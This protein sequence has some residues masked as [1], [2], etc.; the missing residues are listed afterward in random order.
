LRRLEKELRPWRHTTLFSLL[1]QLIELHTKKHI[2][3]LEFIR[4]S[5]ERPF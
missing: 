3:I 4:R 2:A 1:V 5:A